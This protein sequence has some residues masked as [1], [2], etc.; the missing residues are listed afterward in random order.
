MPS[1]SKLCKSSESAFELLMKSL[2]AEKVK[3][4]VIQ[5]HPAILIP[6]QGDVQ[7]YLVIARI[8][9]AMLIFSAPGFV[10]IPKDLPQGRLLEL[11][12]RLLELN[13]GLGIVKFAIERNK[14]EL[15][16]TTEIP[17][18]DVAF[19]RRTIPIYFRLLVSAVH[20]HQGELL[21]LARTGT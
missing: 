21:T 13:A 1:T 9:G 5:D 6:M 19:V 12:R 18:K 8:S 3:F 16:L 14:N 11:Q 7:D 10:K 20:Q 17:W 2:K 4:S 15:T